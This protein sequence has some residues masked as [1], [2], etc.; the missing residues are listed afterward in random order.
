MIHHLQIQS[1]TQHLFYLGLTMQFFTK[2]LISTTLLSALVAAAPGQ[3]QLKTSLTPRQDATFD[4]DGSSQC[5]MFVDP[6]NCDAAV[7][8]IDENHQ[9]TTL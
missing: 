3:S 5:K 8:S 2:A 9:Y 6:S 7:D 4:C 1:I